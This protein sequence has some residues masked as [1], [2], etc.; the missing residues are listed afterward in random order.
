M[1]KNYLFKPILFLFILFLIFILPPSC[2]RIRLPEIVPGVSKEIADYR[3]SFIDSLNYHLQFSIPPVKEEK[4]TGKAIIHLYLNKKPEKLIVDFNAPDEH[5]YKIIV[6]QL[7]T[8]FLFL[9]EHIVI[10]GKFLQTG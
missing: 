2:Q 8:D 7:H 3:K 4:V 1:K 5:L 9:N 6:N 10:L